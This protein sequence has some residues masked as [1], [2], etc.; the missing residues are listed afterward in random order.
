[1]HRRSGAGA[2]AALA[3]LLPAVMALSASSAVLAEEESI[4]TDRPDF[5]ESGA[6]VGK[7]VFQIE[8]SLARESDR[9][10]GVATRTWIT[11]TLLR[12]GVSARLELRLE[13]D[14]LTRQKVD[15]GASRS[16]DNGMSN[17]AIGVK[18][19]MREGQAGAGT[20]SLAWLAHLELNSGSAAFRGSGVAPSLRLVAEWELPGD[21][22]FGVMPGLAWNKDDNA[23]RYGSAILAATYSRPL[24]GS[25]RGFVELAGR[26]LRS[27][28]HGGNQVTFD[29]GLTYALDKDTQV[30]A[31]IN[32][33]LN[34]DTPDALVTI[35][36]SK[37]FR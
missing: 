8:T 35:G 23:A 31:A 33:G 21:A 9:R 17:S 1:M 6:V 25:L 32:L 14:G 15:D 36:F 24:A 11:P 7:G 2:G 30:D 20:P 18:W 10:D 26:E 27:K 22:A 19:Q 34:R 16:T 29:A 3:R 5:V 37:R 4:A 13:T 12:L 28:R